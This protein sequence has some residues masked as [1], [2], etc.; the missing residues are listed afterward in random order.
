MSTI[1]MAYFFGLEEPICDK[2]GLYDG[3]IVPREQAAILYWMTWLG[4]ITGP[5]GIWNGYTWLGTGTS[6]G[7]IVAQGYWSNPTYS[8][9]RTLDI[10]C[11]QVLLWAHIWVSLSSSQAVLYNLIIAFGGVSYVV[12]WIF[13]RRGQSWAG[14]F[15]HCIV[16]V[17][18]QGGATILYL[19]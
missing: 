3:C 16:H 2:D 1:L 7:V 4:A 14:T 18:G 5:I 6:I 19:S 9:R 10:A 15:A 12:G 13:T 11:V 8:W 17:C